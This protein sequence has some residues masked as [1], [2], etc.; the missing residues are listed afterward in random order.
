[1]NETSLHAAVGQLAEHLP[2][3][4]ASCMWGHMRPQYFRYRRTDGVS[5]TLSNKHFR[6]VGQAGS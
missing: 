1:M 5:K 3:T 4:M 6:S 2:V